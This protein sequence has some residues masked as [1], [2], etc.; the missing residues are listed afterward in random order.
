[1]C[2]PLPL[3]ARRSS[4]STKPH[5]EGYI[6]VPSGKNSRCGSSL[7]SAT[8]VLQSPALADGLRGVAHASDVQVIFELR[9]RPGR[10]EV[11]PRRSSIGADLLAT[12][13]VLK[14]SVHREIDTDDELDGSD[15]T[16]TQRNE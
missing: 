2:A 6:I 8:V 3:R 11:F 12:A 5:S 14:C 7:M 15:L 16:V 1:M 10:R 9:H 4:G 13:D